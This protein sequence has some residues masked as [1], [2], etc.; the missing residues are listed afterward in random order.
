MAKGQKI[1]IAYKARDAF[2]SPSGQFSLASEETRGRVNLFVVKSGQKIVNVSR[3]CK[4]LA[5]DSGSPVIRML[6]QR[7]IDKQSRLANQYCGI[8]PGEQF[9]LVVEG[10]SG[11]VIRPW[12]RKPSSLVD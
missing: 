5:A 8:S 4:T 11:D 3:A 1:A 7:F 6:A 9:H 2:T 10:V 12:V